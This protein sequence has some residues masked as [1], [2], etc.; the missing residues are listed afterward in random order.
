MHLL[1]GRIYLRSGRLR[2]AMDAFKVS[3]WSQE[4]AAAHVALAEAYLEA[5][6][7]AAARG[8]AER[9]L[10]LD[11]KSIHAQKL[12]ERLRRPDSAPV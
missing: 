3:I 7:A 11:P 2:E 6:D 4:T 12:L 10:V 9:A 5:R 8:E 1:L